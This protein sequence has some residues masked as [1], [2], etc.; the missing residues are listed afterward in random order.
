MPVD[1]IA[2]LAEFFGMPGIT[3]AQVAHG[4][5]GYRPGSAGVDP[6]GT[7]GYGLWAITSPFNNSWVAPFGGYEGMWNPIANAI[8][9]AKAY[10]GRGLAPWYGT[11][12]VT[13]TNAHWGGDFGPLKRHGVPLGGGNGSNGHGNNGAGPTTPITPV[14]YAPPN[15]PI[16]P[17]GYSPK[18]VRDIMALAAT[19]AAIV[20]D[21]GHAQIM[22]A[23]SWSPG[24]TDLSAG[25]RTGQQNLWRSLIFNRQAQASL[26]PKAIKLTKKQPKIQ[27][28]LVGMLATLT[29]P[30]AGPGSILEALV[31]LDSLTD[32][33]GGGIDTSAIDALKLAEAQ[34]WARRYQV[35]QAQYGAFAQGGV[36]G[37]PPAV[38][39]SAG[40]AN[41]V[42]G[43][44]DVQVY[45]LPDGNAHVRV[46]GQGFD[47]K[48]QTATRGYGRRVLP[49]A[50]GH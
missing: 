36:I 34:D 35:S 3:M 5:S 37:G 32:A 13:D 25:E 44:A 33:G 42:V 6:G 43:N 14:G 21:I 20:G 22:D 19:G 16:V 30:L 11:H 39:G 28:P 47:S 15:I 26:L 48:V 40:G 41:T 17:G 38:T 49:G 10:A 50:R 31:G 8:V 45:M 9:A 29:D 18:E 23:F 46:N 7:K 2:E 1:A 27:K 24:G 4:E 12:Y